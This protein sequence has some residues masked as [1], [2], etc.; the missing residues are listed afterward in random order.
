MPNSL[1]TKS[2]LKTNSKFLGDMRSINDQTC[3]YMYGLAMQL[4]L[5]RHSPNPMLNAL[6]LGKLHWWRSPSSI[7]LRTSSTWSFTLESSK[8]GTTPLMIFKHPYTSAIAIY[9][10]WRMKACRRVLIPT[11]IRS[12]NICMFGGKV[13]INS[14]RATLLKVYMN[15]EILRTIIDIGNTWKYWFPVSKSNN[16]EWVQ[17]FKL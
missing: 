6:M 16:P 5:E 4:N 11:Y 1:W 3:S 14:T 9:R 13:L 12:C 2:I 15:S 10:C 17:I 8:L 7:Y